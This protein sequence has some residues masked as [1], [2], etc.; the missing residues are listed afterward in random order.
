MIAGMARIK[1]IGIRGVHKREYKAEMECATSVSEVLTI[2]SSEEM[3]LNA[4]LLMTSLP[5]NSFVRKALMENR[6]IKNMKDG[7]YPSR[8]IGCNWYVEP[9]RKLYQVRRNSKIALGSIFMNKV[10]SLLGKKPW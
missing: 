2:T 10:Y 8:F 1:N 6:S 4:E 3:H 5:A 9:W 7:K